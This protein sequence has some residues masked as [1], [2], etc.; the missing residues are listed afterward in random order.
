VEGKF[1]AS[2]TENQPLT[3]LKRQSGQFP[4]A[5]EAHLLPTLTS[6]GLLKRHAW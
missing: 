5:P 2:L 4:D 1:W 6:T 3:Y